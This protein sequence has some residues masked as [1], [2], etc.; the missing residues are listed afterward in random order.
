VFRWQLAQ[1][2]PPLPDLS[3]LAYWG[4]AGTLATIIITGLIWLYV[5]ERKAH[6][7][8]QA[9][10]L[11]EVMPALKAAQSELADRAASITPDEAKRWARTMDRLEARLDA[12]DR[13]GR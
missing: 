2:S 1:T 3:P 12:D 13:R 8:L 9:K 6:W 10:V 5:T 4:V 11:D 7:S